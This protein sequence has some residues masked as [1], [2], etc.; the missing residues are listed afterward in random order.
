MS[1]FMY[2]G[3]HYVMRLDGF[4]SVNAGFNEGEFVTKPLVFSGD[5]LEL[6]CSTAGAGRIRVEI[7]SAEG[8]PIPG[9]SLDDCDA[10][11]GD[12][13]REVVTWKRNADVTSFAGKPVR[14]KF[15]MKEADLYSL[16]FATLKAQ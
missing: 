12:F 9:H 7:Q 5:E 13:I 3:A 6:N 2:G 10:I 11:K 16:R 15:A 8:N 4:I 14:L 1:L